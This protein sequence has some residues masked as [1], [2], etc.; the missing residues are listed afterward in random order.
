LL[1]VLP[2]P[3][4]LGQQ[5]ISFQTG[6]ENTP[7]VSVDP[8]NPLNVVAVWTNNDQSLTSR[9]KIFVD[10]ALSTDGGTTWTNLALFGAGIP[11]NLP[12]PQNLVNNA[13]LPFYQATDATV[14]FDRSGNFYVA[15]MEHSQD[16]NAG[17]I[18]LH[19]YHLSGG[20][21]AVVF[22]NHVL[23][24]WANS[25]AAQADQAVNL[26]MAVDT[27]LASF[28]D[29]STGQVQTDPSSNSV[30]LAW[31][32][33]Y[34][35]PSPN[36][37]GW[38]PNAIL[39]I[40]S[41]DGGVT[42]SNQD[43]VNASGFSGGPGH[44]TPRLTISQGTADGRVKGG[45]VSVVWNYFGS[46]TSHA[47]SWEILSN[48]L[49]GAQAKVATSPGGPVLEATD[50]GNGQPHIPK[51]NLFPVTV[52]ITDPNFTLD[53]ATVN[54]N[55]VH[56][57]LNEVRILLFAP[58]T[59]TYTFPDGVTKIQNVSL[60]PVLLV[61]NQIDASGN[62][63]MPPQGINGPNLGIVNGFDV[64]TTFDQNAP[65][66]ITNP[67]FAAPFVGTFQPEFSPLFSNLASLNGR[68]PP[69][70]NGTWTL[71]VIDY[72][73]DTTTPTDS[74]HNWTLDLTSGFVTGT[75]SVVVSGSS[76][77]QGT[78]VSPT[79]DSNILF[80]GG[81]VAPF[82]YKIGAS[83]G[84]GVSP[85]PVIASDNTLGSFSP[86][87][88]RLY[89]AFTGHIPG[90]FPNTILD[91][92][93]P[94]F[95]PNPTDNTDIF[96]VTSDDG[97]LTWTSNLTQV[98]SD[99][100]FVNPFPGAPGIIQANDSFSEGL[101]PQFD[102]AVAVDPSTGTLVMSFYDARYDA[103]GVRVTTTVAYSIDGGQTYSPENFANAPKQALDAIERKTVTLEP[104]PDNESVSNPNED[105][106]FNYGDRLGLAVSQGRIYPIWAGNLNANN[107]GPNSAESHRLDIMAAQAVIPGGP[108]IIHSSMGP[109][110][111]VKDLL[112]GAVIN[113]TLAGDGTRLAD[114]FEVEFDR[115]IDP[116]PANFSPSAVQVIFRSPTT[117]A[118]SPGIPL[119]IVSVTDLNPGPAQGYQVG[120]NNFD[121]IFLV[122]FDPSKA[123]KMAGT[124]TG[125][126]SYAVG[127]NVRDRIRLPGTSSPLGRLMDQNANAVTGEPPTPQS[128]GDVYAVP[129]PLSGP[130]F[131]LPYDQST[132]PLIVP[133]PHVA[134]TFV[135]GAPAMVQQWTGSSENL[136]PNTGNLVLNGTVSSLD[137][138][139]DR[140]MDPSSIA[141]AAI[142]RIMGP[143]G[144][145][146]GPFTVTPDYPDPN[147]PRQF[148][149]NFPTQQLSGTYTI[150]LAPTVRSK[151]GEQLDTNQNAGLF[152]L[153]GA[154]P[155]NNTLTSVTH[156][157]NT[158]VSLPPG[159]VTDSPI[160]FPEAFKLLGDATHGPA[161]V[162]LNIK[163]ADD[164]DLEATLI[165][166]D[167]TRIR[168]FT[169]VGARPG[170]PQNDFTNTVLDDFAGT[171]IQ[172][173]QP[174][175]TGS[176]NPQEPLAGLSGKG[177]T[178]TWQL[179]IKNDSTT[180]T[181]TLLGWSLTLN[182]HVPGS[183]LGEAVADQANVSFRIFTM[184][185]TNALD[186]K[187]WTAVGPTSIGDKDPVTGNIIPNTHVGRVTGLAVDPS[188]PSGNTV[189]VGGASGG[190]WKTTNFLTTDPLGPT[191]IP[192]TDFGPTFAIN[193]G[194]IDV[195][196]RNNDPRQSIV[197]A[198]TGEGDTHSQGVGILKSTDGGATWTL[199]DSSTNVDAQGNPLPFNSP[200]RDHIF[201]GTTAYKILVD[202]RPSPS[203]EQVVYAALS[204][205]SGTAK[206]GIWRS[207]DSGK[208]WTKVRAGQ[209]TD[210]VFAPE[211][212]FDPNNLSAP[213]GNITTLYA[214]FQG[215]GVY[216]TQDQGSTWELMTGT[217]G[218]PL[219]R[220]QDSTSIPVDPPADVP[221]GAKGRIVLATPSLLTGDPTKDLAYEGWLY[222]VVVTAGTASRTGGG[223]LQGVYLT[224]DFGQNW[225]K[226]HLPYTGNPNSFPI[227]DGYPS[228]DQTRPDYDPYG[229]AQF[230]QGNYDISLAID[231]NNPNIV[232]IGGTS[233]GNPYGLIRLDSSALSDPKMAVPY[234][235]DAPDTG[236]PELQTQGALIPKDNTLPVGLVDSV[237]GAIVPTINA[238]RD[239]ENPFLSNATL[240]AGVLPNPD[241]FTNTG[242]GALWMPF[243]NA[244]GGSTD[245]HRVISM[246]DPVTGRTRLIW[247][248]DQ[249][250]FTGV[251]QGNGQFFLSVGVADHSDPS[252]DVPVINGTRDG[253]LQ[254]TQFYYGAAQPS[255]LAAQIGQA[256]F[257]G[258]AQ[259]DGFPVSDP[260]LLDNGNLEWVGPAG[261][262]TGIATDQTGKGTV[263]TYQWPCC[264]THSQ[265][266][267]FYSV[268]P[269][270]TAG[271]PTF[272]P[273][274]GLF[275]SRTFG[276]LQHN[277][278]G[279]TP[280]PQ[281]PFLGGSNF[282][283]NPINGDQM[284]IG[285][286]QGRVFRTK[287][288]GLHWEQIGFVTGDPSAI[289][290][291]N[292]VDGTYPPTEA[293]G[294]PEPT[295]PSGNLDD[296]I[297]VGTSGG[298]IFVTFNGGGQWIDISGGLDGSAVQSISASPR[299]GSHEAYAVT[300]N[301]VYYMANSRTST[302]WTN[303]T[304]NL[305]QLTANFSQHNFL[306]PTQGGAPINEQ[307]VGQY[308]TAVV[309][310]WRFVV[311]DNPANPN[312]PSHTV[313]YVGG[314]AGVFRS[315]DKGKTWTIFPNVANDGSPVDGGY[316]PMAHITDLR[317]S[318]GNINPT[319]GNPDQ[320]TGPNL[321]Y[322]VTYGR[323]TFVIRL[324]TNS[325][326]NPV[327]GPRVVSASPSV[328]S[329]GVNVIHLGFSGPVDPTT[330]TL[331][332]IR[333]FTGP[334]GPITAT[335]V[336][337]VGTQFNA[338]DIT[339]P[340]Q[341][342]SGTYTIQIGPN[343]S[344]FA[345]HLMDQNGN[346]ING[347]DPGDR[348]VFQF[349]IDTTDN[350]HF[351]GGLYND[352]LG[353][354]PDVGGFNLNLGPIN[355]ARLAALPTLAAGL[356][357]SPEARTNLVTRYYNLFFPNQP[358]PQAGVNFWVGQLAQGRNP[359]DVI[360]GMVGS[361]D[362][363]SRASIGQNDDAFL[364]QM[365][366]DVLKRAVDAGAR[367][368][369]LNF[370]AGAE[371]SA[372]NTLANNI[373]HSDEYYAQLLNNPTDGFYPRFLGRTAA[374]GD[375]TFWTSQLH[376]GVTD[377]Q[378]IANI[379]AT[380]EY[381]NRAPAIIG[382]PANPP[383][384]ATFIQA[385]YVQLFGRKAS[386]QEVQFWLPQL[387]GLGR[388]K[389]ALTLMGTDEYRRALV[390]GYYTK[391]LGIT[392]PSE[393]QLVP[394]LQ[395]LLKGNTDEQVLSAFLASPDYYKK[396]NPTPAP[397]SVMDTNWAQS[398]YN[399]VLLRPIDSGGLA[400][401]QNYLTLAEQNSRAS[402]VQ[403]IVYSDEYRG[404]LLYNPNTG[405]NP[406]TATGFYPQLL[407]RLPAPSEVSFWVSYIKTISGGPGKPS[408]DE[409]VEI[410]L[411]SSAEYMAKVPLD[412]QGLQS[413]KSWLTSLYTSPIILNRAPDPAG[414]NA[415]LNFL[416]NSYQPQRYADAFGL[417]TSD[418]YKAHLVTTM[419]QKYLRR[420]PG[421]SEVASQV[422][423][424][425]AGHTDEQLIQALV[426]SQEY[427]NYAANQRPDLG[428]D[429]NS[430]FVSL[431]YLDLLTRPRDPSSQ[432]LINALNAGQ[433]SRSQV[434]G[435]IINTNEYRATLIATY[436]NQYLHRN[437]PKPVP[438]NP[439][440]P[441]IAG[442]VQQLLKGAT[443]E[444]VIASLVASNEY[445][446]LPHPLQ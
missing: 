130:P 119:D 83:P 338:F 48:Q 8:T 387:P 269:P 95:R 276:L 394:Y 433:L 157:S 357:T 33:I 331:D 70:L 159:K 345:G 289:P 206:G 306:L 347:E 401:I 392:N 312:G 71:A 251:D 366:S 198:V 118:S 423:Y 402:V 323:G 73:A 295:N 443:D 182:Q 264:G 400:G 79:I 94:R 74:L 20:F 72:R 146:N 10:G 342:L 255:V 441:E 318:V 41:S 191:Y 30:Y 164:R 283:V 431:L 396:P 106:T 218:N 353:R 125:T 412:D 150:T 1:S 429:G 165:A 266:T 80:K 183:G 263:Y 169:R 46:P 90:T 108:R 69:Q 123:L 326:F 348:F 192:L 344:D 222:A 230:M 121:T 219:I 172:L 175:F 104:I 111:G 178:G 309:A 158:Q 100:S 54:L 133:G 112:S 333:S 424:L 351:V 287:D 313:L 397:L 303:I 221:N 78:F 199:L 301:G 144:Q 308:L 32:T 45:Q 265:T 60:P 207:F 211:S 77:L 139:F 163:D 161:T 371:Q 382:Q 281:W 92:G 257:Y 176:F 210:V 425:K 151:I 307:K 40:G 272:D 278:P 38:N 21:P 293:Y 196:G 233:D 435:M 27:N 226:I 304:G 316:L 236:L 186:Q 187:V 76:M 291:V 16:N 138:V 213:P 35:P 58:G 296:F 339:F 444:Q 225:T 99:S 294:A 252:G 3:S 414:F 173:G 145:I 337:P 380:A 162:L 156:S 179:E 42:F 155:T 237:T 34:P 203:G 231:P 404:D 82:P 217:A 25:N 53:H 403:G 379:V 132:L 181:G 51:A 214:G 349:I 288:Q 195:F 5:D 239:P 129:L 223:R 383:T 275:A 52:N 360:V 50:P 406:A 220:R 299:R 241:H 247:A 170:L 253:N 11:T 430:R 148:R 227:M 97:G 279:L 405:G 395:L 228:N 185:P 364:T 329:P 393:P 315:M 377:E 137:V 28:K 375:V 201:V 113:T 432:G 22:T 200:Q 56:A 14:A 47:A 216:K 365:Y 436:Y 12:D 254:V 197:Y 292:T 381:Y 422:A 439:N 324:P 194:G 410:N 188:D 91:R 153:Q 325:P 105:T 238:L 300:L 189:Y 250:V 98:N 359:E 440:D 273:R 285:S 26:T 6:D 350:G 343:I 17:D 67:N 416:L 376:Q 363:F 4:V 398:V 399:D 57:N 415:N 445:F 23:Y 335:A 362:Y 244:L 409:Q 277:N 147:H 19:K 389:F 212:A 85:A 243:V 388:S 59:G 171:P 270:T 240:I 411:V 374:P 336:I 298:K 65:R 96:L 290:G 9:Q 361:A 282:A 190:I 135:P 246:R 385:L 446:L 258:N 202:P 284:V 311:P 140:D 63:I 280:D 259:D 386:D 86:F 101:R 407:G 328:A 426:S 205:V 142:L 234:D 352:L 204:D 13:A 18:V 107:G 141:G 267:D 64:G 43:I 341:T 152:V 438:G 39:A 317:L 355:S 358:V 75:Q 314:E 319:T 286:Q 126:Y 434:A 322:A 209:A 66:S 37:P 437:P 160:S 320:A 61:N 24:R 310:D 297:Y 408:P 62:T 413:G 368:M 421:P 418:E 321:L 224:K 180:N 442:W 134:S 31:N 372:R 327:S 256:L 2:P 68:K 166:P 208:H 81:D 262:G 354:G 36:A 249:G 177:S 89:V 245:Q 215:D 193:I 232:Y 428:P 391:Y 235:E 84:R 143:A 242:D 417:V 120:Q 370:L 419:Y 302:T 49:S 168:L 260:N 373:T 110:E 87:Q 55:L 367:T 305:F 136:V 334:A 390:R 154:D 115:P 149:I 93:D 378:V 427:F 271:Q 117:A 167:G 88:G 116:D 268:N 131:Q 340:A 124:Y 229:N 330:F 274:F 128:P 114:R 384:D 356:I 248:D 174:P 15:E 29:D 261:D 7:S 332:D 44:A 102:P 103:A 369:F 346:G 420:T 109:V 184:D 127:P 122:K